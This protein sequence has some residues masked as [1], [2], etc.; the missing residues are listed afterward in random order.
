MSDLSKG[1]ILTFG[2]DSSADIYAQDIRSEGFGQTTF[3][4]VTPTG[5]AEVSFQLNGLHN[6]SNALAAA[7]VAHSFGMRA[8]QIA[9]GLSSVSAPP[10]RG[11]V[12]RFAEGFTVINDSYNSN[13]T[14]LLSMAKTLVEGCGPAARKIVVAGEMLELGS[15]EAAIHRLAGRELAAS[16]IDRLIGIRGLAKEMVEGA[17]EAGLAESQFAVDSDAAGDLLANEIRRGD[18]VLIKGSRGVRTEKVIEKLMDRF[19]LEDI[20]KAA[21]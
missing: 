19:E 8:S 6:I 9:A 12:L 14:A 18:V 1:E 20:K 10:Q 21:G 11:E 7:A 2:I 4:L 15:D 3:D 17:T 5:K 13:P 16:G